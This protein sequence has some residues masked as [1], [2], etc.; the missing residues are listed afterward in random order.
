MFGDE[1]IDQVRVMSDAIYISMDDG[2]IRTPEGPEARRTEVVAGSY[3]LDAD[4]VTFSGDPETVKSVTAEG[5]VV[6]D[7]PDLHVA[8]DSITLNAENRILNIIGNVV[9][10]IMGQEGRADE[11]ELNF[12]SGWSIRLVGASVGGTIDSEMSETISSGDEGDE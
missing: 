10:S 4:V 2:I 3:T 7:G 1:E 9:F 11:V 8:A 6:I 12:A 5:E